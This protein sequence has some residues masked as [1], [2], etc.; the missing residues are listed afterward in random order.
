M[1]IDASK[2]L[3]LYYEILPKKTVKAFEFLKNQS[4]LQKDGW[5][6]AGG[7]ALALQT[8]NRKSVDLDFFTTES[9][10]LNKDIFSNFENNK[11]WKTDVDRKNTVYGELF[12]AKVSFI[13]YPFF[14]PKQEYIQEGAIKVLQ[15]R[16]IAVMKIIAVS[17]RGRKRDFFDL[18]W[19]ARH[20]EPL[21]QTIKRLPEQYPSVA[22]DYHHI[23]KA[24]V[25]FDDAESDPDPEINF[26]AD[27]RKVKDFFTEEIPVIMNKLVILG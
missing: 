18:Y 8:G 16:D 1:D 23:L 3:G 22:H 2:Q 24:L 15:P 6:L 14:I 9:N 19:C 7:T 20:V 13:A 4:W 10:F 21:E 26:E 25:Y 5:Y 12:G 17:Q 27:W 11:D